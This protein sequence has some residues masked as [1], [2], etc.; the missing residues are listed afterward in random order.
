VIRV[1]LGED[2]YLVREGIGRIVAAAP[3]LE[4]VGACSDVDALRSMVDVLEPDLVLTD[5]R[6]PPTRTDEGVRLAC[7]L[8]QSHPEVGVVVLSQHAS[9]V[10]ANAL[11]ADGAGGRGYALKDRIADPDDLTR[12]LREVAAGRSHL[13]PA[14]VDVVFTG[15]ERAERD[16]LKTLTPREREVLELLAAGLNNA[17][18]ADELSISTRAVERHINSIFQK[19][20]IGDSERVSRRVMATLA[21]LSAPH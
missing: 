3:D 19:L 20:E 17:A 16:R 7:E 4:L 12:I 15:W 6:M 5:I 18:I 10:Y 14:V 1:V 13:D 9:S 21:F 2:S 11:F 8:R